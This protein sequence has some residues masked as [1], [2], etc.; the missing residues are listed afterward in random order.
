VHVSLHRAEGLGL[1]MLESMRLG[2]PVIATGWSGNMSY[3]DH[4]SACLV[5]YRLIEVAGKHVNYRAE[6]LGS[7]AVW[8][9]PVVED[10]VAWMRHLHS[11]PDQRRRIGSAGREQAER[12]Q[13]D[14]VHLD[15]LHELEQIWSMS[16]LLPSAPGK[17]R[18][19]SRPG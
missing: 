8:A 17:F 15:W 10:A 5:R 18:S 13:A 6:T 9:D 16:E 3:M 11:H 14:A 1:G 12:Y 19:G 2:V 7:G 4:R